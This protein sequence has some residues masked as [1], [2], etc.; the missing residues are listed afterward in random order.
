[1]S[2]PSIFLVLAVGALQHVYSASANA[3]HVKRTVL[4]VDGD[5]ARRRDRFEEKVAVARRAA[6]R[7]E[8]G[9][10]RGRRRA[11][12]STFRL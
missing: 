11:R 4:I 6:P 1:M 8:S 5:R 10:E 12:T 3:T 2:A 9:E 7:A